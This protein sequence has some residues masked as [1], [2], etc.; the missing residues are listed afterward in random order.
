M[1]KRFLFR[2]GHKNNSPRW[3]FLEGFE[4][5]DLNNPDVMYLARIR[6]VQT[7]WFGIYI[8]RIGTPDSRKVLH[9]HPWPF[10]SFLLR[11]EYTEMVPDPGFYDGQGDFGNPVF[12][13]YAVPRRVRFINVKRFNKSYHWIDEIH[14]DPV[15]TLV[16]VG[17]RKRTW[18]YLEP[19]GSYYDF[20]KH[21]IN[22]EFQKVMAEKYGGGDMV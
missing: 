22:D 4:I 21:P 13:E 17:R 7:P 15:W 18:G 14:R 16:F 5:P 10:V 20:D 3:A 2:N 1:I 8:H 6:V 12:V 9:S 19:D 11:G